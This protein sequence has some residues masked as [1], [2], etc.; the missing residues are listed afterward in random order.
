MIS[1]KN[2]SLQNTPALAQKIGNLCLL[3]AAIGTSIVGLPATLQASGIDGFILPEYILTIGKVCIA[4]G[5]FSKIFTKLFGTD[6]P[7]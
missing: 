5:V 6:E 4:I 1:L 3:V 7:K 2:F